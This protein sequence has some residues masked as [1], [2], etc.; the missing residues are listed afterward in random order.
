MFE[1]NPRSGCIFH[2]HLFQTPTR[3]MPTLLM[4][5]CLLKSSY[6]FIKGQ[7]RDIYNKFC[8]DPNR[9]T[10]A[11]VCCYYSTT[12]VNYTFTRQPG[13]QVAVYND[14]E[15]L[16]KFTA[17]VFIYRDHSYICRIIADQVPWS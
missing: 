8:S 6:F 14:G 7:N 11:V 17:L 4:F 15:A 1:K 12:F 16:P 5:F 13:K 2:F 9:N 3:S 10:A